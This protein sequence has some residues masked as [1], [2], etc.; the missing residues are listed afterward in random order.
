[1]AFFFNGT[2]MGRTNFLK[3]ATLFAATFCLAGCHPAQPPEVVPATTAFEVDAAQAVPE[4]ASAPAPPIASGKVAQASPDD[5]DFI[6]WYF[7]RGGVGQLQ[8]CGASVP[9]QLADSTF[10]QELKRKLGN[11]TMPVYVSLRIRLAPESR[12]EVTEVRQFGSD[13]TPIVGCDLNQ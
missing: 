10:L 13:E 11:G 3:S 4:I 6:G 2:D 12:L 8:A 1:M 7:E 9:L 5:D